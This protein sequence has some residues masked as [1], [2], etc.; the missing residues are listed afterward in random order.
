ML[1]KLRI[2]RNKATIRFWITF[3]LDI[4]NEKD[5]E[6]MTS[7]SFLNCRYYAKLVDEI[8]TPIR[9]GKG[10]MARYKTADADIAIE[11][12]NNTFYIYDLGLNQISMPLSRAETNKVLRQYNEGQKALKSENIEV[13]EADKA[14]SV[15]EK[16]SYALPDA[17]SY[18]SN[19]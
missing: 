16:Q 6:S 5:E 18:I 2:L 9:L 7:S 1:Y 15:S 19:S 4:T 17:S 11:N 13:A 3:N 8:P 14:K 12:D 10:K